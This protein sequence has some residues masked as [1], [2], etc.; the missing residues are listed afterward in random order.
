MVKPTRP[1][2]ETCVTSADLRQWYWL[3]TELTTEARRR[4]LSTSGGKFDILARICAQIDGHALPTAAP[5]PLS[6]FDWHVGPVDRLTEITDNYRNT[7]CVRRFFKSELGDGFHFT[8]AMI[9]WMRGNVGRSMADA[10][11][12]ARALQAKAAS[13]GYQTQIKPHNQW[14]A[15]LRAFRADNP[16]LGLDAARATWAR[17]RMLPSLDGRHVYHRS[18]LDLTD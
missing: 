2:I 17:K 1:S 7:Q 4:G 8:I 12:A 3:K 16:N 13:P 9:D 5:K 14:N 6:R 15:Y 10:V 11:D 18:D